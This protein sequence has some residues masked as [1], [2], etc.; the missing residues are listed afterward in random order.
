MSGRMAEPG[1][2]RDTG[3]TL[4]EL[5]VASMVSL[6][7][8][9]V[10]GSLLINS[11]KTE[12]TVR[13][14]TQDTTAG[15]LVAKSVSQGVRNATDYWHSASGSVPELL[16]ART[17]GSGSAWVCQAWSFADGEVRMIRS[18]AAIPKTQTT[19]SIQGWTLLAD[20]VEPPTS[21]SVSLPVFTVTGKQVDLD[22]NVSTGD[23]KPTL[24]HTS[25]VSRLEPAAAGA[26]PACF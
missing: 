20:G 14:A 25:S 17:M 8:L 22:F 13:T 12:R 18:A 19:T 4:I 16:M 6:I 9:L 7:I 5:L 15:Q 2:R 3:F 1:E 24:I 11:L 23:P 21:G 26:S 10:V